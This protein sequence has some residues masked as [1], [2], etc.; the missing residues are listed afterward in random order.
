M[1]KGRGTNLDAARVPAREL[2]LPFQVRRLDPPLGIQER[3]E[4]EA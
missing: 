4:G 1:K 2:V 3:L